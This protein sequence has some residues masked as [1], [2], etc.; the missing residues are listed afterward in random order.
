MSEDQ[1]GRI[2]TSLPG[3]VDQGY[4]DYKAKQ[5]CTYATGAGI[6]RLFLLTAYPF[7]IM[8][9]AFMGVRR[10][11]AVK[12]LLLFGWFGVAGFYNHALASSPRYDA[13]TGI[14]TRPAN[15]GSEEVFIG[16]Y[17]YLNL[18]FAGLLLVAV[19]FRT[20]QR[21]HYQRKYRLLVPPDSDGSIALFWRYTKL[22]DW[23][24]LVLIEPAVVWWVGQKM[25]RLDAVF[26]AYCLAAFIPVLI[27]GAASSSKQKLG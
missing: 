14:Y 11:S 12:L 6:A 10:V 24:V 21:E 25:A 19:I 3:Q 7:E 20:W 1:I 2:L 9:H 13:E 22:P 23:V 4:R 15:H 16:T 18:W 27:L 5:G 26:S 17:P 8:F